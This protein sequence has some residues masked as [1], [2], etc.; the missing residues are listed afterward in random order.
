MWQA[1]TLPYYCDASLLPAPLPTVADV[2]NTP[3]TLATGS[4]NVVRIGDHF[5]AKYGP[6][7]RLRVQEGLN[8]IFVEQYLKIPIP[9]VYAL[10]E[11]NG[12]GYLIMQYIGGQT[13]EALWPS[14]SS[15][16]RW[17]ILSKLRGIFD[18][19]RSLSPPSPPFFGSVDFGP[20][21]Y[22]LFWTPEP[23][24]RVNGPFT[25]EEE[26]CLGLVERVRQ[27]FAENNMHM[28]RTEWLR[29]YFPRSLTGHRPTFTH[30]DIQRKNI[31]VGRISSTDTGKEEFSVT[32]ID[33]ENAGWYPNYFEY[34]ISYTSPSGR[35]TGRRAS[36][37]SL[38]LSLSRL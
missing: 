5:V 33:W 29:K 38:T 2:E 9:R 16:E 13:L 11:E 19:M 8:M 31:M 6:Q 28:S 10:Y 34:F 35:T 30:G 15:D 18:D 3:N 24:K 23:Q 27:I 17:V 14:L 32:I 22:F 1:P 12:R 26:F 21:P 25:N 36:K 7:T 20:L 4:S 37:D